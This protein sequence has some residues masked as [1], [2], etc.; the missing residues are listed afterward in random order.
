LWIDWKGSEAPQDGT[1]FRFTGKELDAETGLYYYGARYLDPKTSRWLSADPAM[2]EYVPQAGKGAGGLPGMGG[3]YNTV[4][5]HTY[6]YAG[7]NP[8]K[9]RDPDGRISRSLS[10]EEWSEVNRVQDETI[11][12]LG[13][14]IGEIENY[15]SGRSDSISSEIMQ[16]A[17][18]WLGIDISDGSSAIGLADDLKKTRNNLASKTRNDF[19][20]NDKA[21]Y[22]GLV[23]PF[24]RKIYLGP[25][26]RYKPDVLGSSGTVATK[27]GTLFHEV[28]HFLTVLSTSD[29]TENE[30]EARL[31]AKSPRM[32]G[33]IPI[34]FARN[35]AYNW[36]MFFQGYAQVRR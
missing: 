20:V 2:G 34:L 22:L 15:V 11:K 6:H 3:V 29:I 18:D 33:Y 23:I 5:L 1:P 19:R 30:R 31:L 32:D 17:M 27:H 28:T 35:S 13:E 24:G 7:N 21:D 26:F 25:N 36:E 8:V 12:Y 16:G 4:N 10:E 9:Y 14:M